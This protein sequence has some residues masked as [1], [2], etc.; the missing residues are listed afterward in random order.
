M[1][2]DAGPAKLAKYEDHINFTSLARQ[3]DTKQKT[4]D[5]CQKYNLIP[6]EINCPVCECKLDKIHFKGEQQ[7]VLF[8]CFKSTCRKDISALK[9]TWFENRNISIEKSLVLTYCFSTKA[10]YDFAIRETS[11]PEYGFKETSRETVSDTFSYCREV[12]S[13]IL[14]KDGNTVVGG[15][16]C[17][18]EID[19]AKFGK[20]KYNRGRVVEGQWVFGGICRETKDCFFVAVQDRTA[21]TLLAL[22]KQHI[23]PGSIIHSDCF[24]S[25]NNIEAELG[26]QHYTVNHSENFVDPTTGCHTNTIE[27]TWWSVKRS[28][29]SSHTRQQNFGDHLAEYMYFRKIG[30]SG[31]MFSQFLLDIG[32]V[33]PGL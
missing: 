31:K 25:Y 20:R 16:G 22:I 10:S 33:Y 21:E 7:K 15:P 27:S 30:T 4:V 19:E 26:H 11:G 1:A 12:C 18:V 5:F 8:R 9:N 3:T 28:L 17:I 14:F 23:R 32:R 6:K 13:E 29:R 2:N 24:A